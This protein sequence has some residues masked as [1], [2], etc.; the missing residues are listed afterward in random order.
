MKL[1]TILTA[2]TL[3]TGG[4]FAQPTVP[5]KILLLDAT[6]IQS[7]EN[8]RI[9]VGQA[10]KFSANPLFGEEH[11]WEARFD[12]MYP[13][14]IWDESDQLYKC[15]YNP[16]LVEVEDW[17][18]ST[19]TRQ[20]WLYPKQSGL[21]YA[22]S[23][24]GIRWVKPRLDILPFRGQLSNILMR[25]AHGVGVFRDS[26]ETNPARRYKSFFVNEDAGR[27]TTV[28]VSFSANGINWG[29]QTLVT[30]AKL[31]ADTHNNALWAPTLNR[32]VA[33]TRDWD[34]NVPGEI[35]AVRLVARIESEDFEHWTDPQVVL[36]GLDPAH[37]VYA[38]PVFYY[39]GIYIGLPVI[40]D[41]ISD[42]THAEL[43]W[44]KDTVT[45][46]RVDVGTYVIPNSEK[47]GDF[48]FGCIYPAAV[49][50]IQKDGIK[51]YYSGSDAP[52]WAKRKAWLALATLRPD[53]F[54]AATPAD[55]SKSG[56]I[57]TVPVSFQGKDKLLLTA[58]VEEG[59]SIQV[60][61]LDD[62]GREVARSAPLAG[63]FTSRLVEWQAPRSPSPDHVRLSF[64]L[65]RA[66]LYSYD[67]VAGHRP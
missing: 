65:T 53:G 5:R 54:A 57:V 61:A 22:Y 58:D 44:S 51:L 35:K 14:V 33:F 8:I 55:Q 11:P 24:D 19:P 2:G 18:T 56:K 20:R 50:I 12:N 17:L 30:N 45:W 60:T 28:A 46:H 3:L 42:R 52:H 64:T 62:Q 1:I 27:R 63:S 59:G 48:D 37:Q 41:I 67:L 43:A 4:L 32:Y 29:P 21:C 47:K 49:P 13:N 9:A 66:R 26:R 16:F 15:W 6:L 39:A 36:R 31:M 10:V 38:M 23:K 34:R 7:S 25:D 40:F